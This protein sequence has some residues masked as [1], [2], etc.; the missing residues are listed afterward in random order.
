MKSLRQD[1]LNMFR[2]NLSRAPLLALILLPFTSAPLLGQEANT[3]RSP[4]PAMSADSLVHACFVPATGTVYRIGA[5][6][7][8]DTCMNQDHVHF[9]WNSRGPEG[10]PGAT[11]APGEQGP[12]GA[13]GPRGE[14]GP[15]GPEGVPGPQGRTGD[16]GTNGT[17]GPAGPQ[18]PQG[19]QGETGPIGGEGPAGTAGETGPQGPAGE[20]GTVGPQGPAGTAGET[21][22]QGPGGEAG[23]VGPQGPAGEAGETGPPG[24]SG[25]SG[26]ELAYGSPTAMVS[27]GQTVTRSATCPVGKI[28]MSGGHHTGGFAA[29]DAMVNSS[30]TTFDTPRVWSVT[31]THTG[32]SDQNNFTFYSFAVCVTAG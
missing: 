16:A 10:A 13:L 27:P 19:P 21:G 22:P 3:V 4:T 24:S 7:L 28:A 8:R 23:G 2:I 14:Q 12:Q 18:G 20:A 15:A 25:V 6:G 32:L 5:P 29:V 11:G 17:Q 26:M 30:W 31:V 9:S 1:T